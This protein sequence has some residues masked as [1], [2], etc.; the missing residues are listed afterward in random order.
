ML[1][2]L[3]YKSDFYPLDLKVIQ[4]VPELERVITVAM[5]TKQKI[6]C[7]DGGLEAYTKLRPIFSKFDMFEN[8]QNENCTFVRYFN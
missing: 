5:K 7:L 3:F 6:E 4:K 2:P 8:Y 1:A